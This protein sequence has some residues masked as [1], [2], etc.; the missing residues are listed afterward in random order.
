MSQEEKQMSYEEEQIQQILLQESEKKRI[1]MERELKLSQEK[2][3]E[4][5]LKEDMRNM[6]NMREMNVSP[7]D[8]LFDEPS[9]EE[10]RRVRLLRFTGYQLVKE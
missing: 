6:G 8:K 4:A 5:S 3:Y 1:E 9:V 7:I 2:E 10:M